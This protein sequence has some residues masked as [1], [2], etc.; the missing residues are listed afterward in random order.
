[1]TFGEY[2]LV[3][4]SDK[5]LLLFSTLLC[6]HGITVNTFEVRDKLEEVTWN[7]NMLLVCK[8]LE[9]AKKTEY[10]LR[11]DDTHTITDNTSYSNE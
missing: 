7:T 8:N 2:L 4:S 11:K 1:M 6:I 3:A 9:E 5:R 10:K